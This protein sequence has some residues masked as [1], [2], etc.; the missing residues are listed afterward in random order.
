[1]R[2]VGTCVLVI[3][4]LASL[5]V[6]Q[7]LVLPHSPLGWVLLFVLGIPIWFLLEWAGERTFGLKFFSNLSSPVRVLVAVPF[8]IVLFTVAALLAWGVRWAA[9]Q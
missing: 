6:L 5:L 2:K 8:A 1:M 4:L 3:A 9:S 7:F